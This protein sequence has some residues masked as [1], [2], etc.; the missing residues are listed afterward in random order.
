MGSML[1]AIILMEWAP[2]VCWLMALFC[3]FAFPHRVRILDQ[4]PYIQHRRAVWGTIFFFIGIALFLVQ[5]TIKR[6]TQGHPI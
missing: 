4:L 6:L 1:N 3:F 2:L 5:I